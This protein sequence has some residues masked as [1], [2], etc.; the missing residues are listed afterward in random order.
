M[1]YIVEAGGTN[2]V[3]AERFLTHVFKT[4][5]TLGGRGEVDVGES[6]GGMTDG[7]I[8][9]RADVSTVEVG[10]WDVEVRADYGTS[11][12]V[13]KVSEDEDNVWFEVGDGG[14]ESGEKSVEGVEHR[15]VGV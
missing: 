14:G 4:E 3:N 11:E 2:L 15:E 10:N 9:G 13:T 6:S 5:G 12:S 1:G 7:F 8:N